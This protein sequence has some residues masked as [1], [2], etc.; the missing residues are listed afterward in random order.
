MRPRSASKGVSPSLAV[1]AGLCHLGTS[2]AL[3]TRILPEQSLQFY[4]TGRGLDHPSW[5]GQRQGSGRRSPGPSHAAPARLR[6]LVMKRPPAGVFS[7][8]KKNE[9]LLEFVV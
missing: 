6:T 2:T 5:T 7:P 3:G 9:L 8:D 4:S 1:A